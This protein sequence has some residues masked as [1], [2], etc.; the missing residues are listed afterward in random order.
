MHARHWALVFVVGASLTLVLTGCSSSPKTATTSAGNSASSSGA[1][2]TAPSSTSPTSESGSFYDAIA[3]GNTWTYSTDYGLTS[4]G[5]V[6]DTERMTAVTATAD[7]TQA[8]ISRSFHYKNGKQADFVSTATYLFHKDGSVTVP[9]QNIGTGIQIH[10]KSGSIQWPT[11]A[12]FAAG[13]PKTGQIVAVATSNGTTINETINFVTK[14][15]GT[16]SVTV[17]AGTYTA[18]VLNQSVSVSV[19]GSSTGQP[20]DTVSYMAPGT[21]MV[22]SIMKNSKLAPGSSDVTTV[23]TSFTHG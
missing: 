2:G 17:P 11:P 9:Y 12:E 22:K 19:N 15:A 4:L 16:S 6:T 18:H 13:T 23:L 8:T 21:G 10:V 20:I 3:V 14:G 7:G 5:V 1:T